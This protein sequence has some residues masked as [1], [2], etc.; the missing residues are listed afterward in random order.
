MAKESYHDSTNE[1]A[2]NKDLFNNKA[3]AQ[4]II[5]IALFKRNPKMTASECFKMFPDRSTPITSIRRA[6]SNLTRMG[7]LIKLD[8][9]QGQLPDEEIDKNT[10]EKRMGIYGRKEYVYQLV[11]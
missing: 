10:I 9:S 1:S 7:R 11:L 5:I 8:G 3:N 6:I 4:E 2:E